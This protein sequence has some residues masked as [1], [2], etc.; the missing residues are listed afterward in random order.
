MN[1]S[2]IELN[3]QSYSFPKWE[4]LETGEINCPKNY[5]VLKSM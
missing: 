5:N 4:L 3:S 2:K 1:I